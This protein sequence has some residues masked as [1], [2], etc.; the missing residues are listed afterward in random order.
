[1]M[2]ELLCKTLDAVYAVLEKPR[3][4]EPEPEKENDDE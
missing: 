2:L 3:E 4:P 1:M